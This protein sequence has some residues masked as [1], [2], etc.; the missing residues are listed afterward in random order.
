MIGRTDP[1]IFLSL[2]FIENY[3]IIPLGFVKYQHFFLSI[4]SIFERKSCWFQEKALSLHTEIT[5]INVFKQI[6]RCPALGVEEQQ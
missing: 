4:L 3:S 6:N 1:L 5:I 2:D